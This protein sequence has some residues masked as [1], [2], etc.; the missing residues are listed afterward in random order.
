[1]SSTRILYS[2][3]ANE[4]ETFFPGA[5]RDELLAL[6]DESRSI[7]PL[8]VSTEAWRKLLEEFRPSII[9][10]AW[11]TPAIPEDVGKLTAGAFGYFC[12]LAGSVK[13]HI[14]LEHLKGGITV[15][16]WGGVIS[17]TVAEQGLMLAI[18]TLRRANHWALSMHHEKAWKTPETIF[19]SLFE[20][21]VGIHGFGNISRELV[22]LL[23]PFDCRV[24][25]FSPSVPDELLAEHGVARAE[26]LEGLF[27][28][29]DVIIELAALTPATEGI[30][31]ESLLRSIPEGG[32]FVNIGRGA[33]VDEQAL[34]E[35]AR[36]G[37]IQIGLDVFGEE[38]LPADSPFR[39]NKNVM[40]MPHLGGPTTD[41]RQDSGRLAVANIRRFIAGG[42]LEAEITPEVFARAT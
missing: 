8:E 29:N 31:T 19:Y 9:V 40:L 10:S 33:V 16:N 12:Y 36:E 34:A 35:V 42:E 23:K 15:S 21:R 24:S 26:T 22:R 5:L 38:P 2:L 17:R 39:G 32:V 27:A 18:A 3:T 11:R 14:T 7:D 25:T 1:M 20:R 37:R 4:W 28:Q 6:A 30:V 41:R 13:K